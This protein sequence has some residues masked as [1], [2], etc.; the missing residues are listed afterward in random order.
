L[1]VHLQSKTVV[2]SL[3]VKTSKTLWDGSCK[4]KM[5]KSALHSEANLAMMNGMSP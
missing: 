2:M 3:L 1:V 4:R 5:K